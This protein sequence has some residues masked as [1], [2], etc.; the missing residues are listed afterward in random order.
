M[1][2]RYVIPVTV[3]L[4]AHGALLFGFSKS[5]R[6]IKP[7]EY[8][9]I[10]L[11]T[12]SIPPEPPEILETAPAEKAAKSSDDLPPPRGEEPPLLVV[13]VTKPVMPRP[14]LETSPKMD[15]TRIIPDGGVEGGVR[16][17][18]ALIKNLLSG[19]DLDSAPRTRFQTA[20]IYPFEEKKNG[21]A[22][23]VMVD[24]EVDEGGYVRNPRV[25]RSS[26]RAFEEPTLR[27]VAKW[28]FEPGRRHGKIVAF[29]M[30][31]PVVFSLSND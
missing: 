9:I 1:N 5:T 27:A 28:R 30:S 19:L 2:T 7:E 23:D 21:V 31:V 17:G 14:P 24:F 29:R 18:T 12:F 26:S 6:P 3:A 11:C 15:S 8:I 16:D 25:I 22:G 10:P 4:A 20:P 13:D